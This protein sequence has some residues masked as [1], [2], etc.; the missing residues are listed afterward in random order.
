MLR[1]R[2]AYS[3]IGTTVMAIV[4]SGCTWGGSGNNGASAG[5][6]GGNSGNP[7][8]SNT[9]SASPT[10]T[11]EADPIKRQMQQMSLDDKIGQLVLV[12]L[13]GKAAGKEALEMIA[14]FRV[15]GFILF[16]DNIASAEQTQKL[17]NALKAA[18]AEAKA[19][20]PL[21]LSVDQEGGRVNRL[22]ESFAAFPTNRAIGTIGQPAYAADIGKRLGEAVSAIGFN[23]NYA[24]V[25]D[26]DSNPKNPVIGD[27]SFGPGTDTVSKLGIAEMQGIRSTGVVPVVKHFP[28]HGDTAV[29]SHRALPVV[30]KSLDEL[31]KLELVP[32]QRAIAEK[33]DAVMVAHILLPKLDETYPASLSKAVI[34][35][36]LRG[37]LGFD[38]VV[39]TDDMTMGAVLQNYSI[40]EAAVHAVK[41]GTDI[42]LVAHDYD[43]ETAVL[44]ALKKSVEEGKL[45]MSRINESV[46]RILKLKKAF[47][48][49]DTPVERIDVEGINRNIR[50]T[51]QKHTPKK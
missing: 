51:L 45:S 40:G 42:V 13:E 8:T 49:A 18:N 17:L 12:G 10:A 48:L 7:Q 29:D 25:L 44:G 50:E 34:T 24:P 20:A 30:N 5:P 38:G 4:L 2:M 21:W 22:P 39:I 28:G 26:V 31:K 32:F 14:K 43:K 37:E 9:P 47:K 27:R 6:S 46:Y 36:L 19:A 3:F 11:P 35:D 15:G 16:K 1:G 41:A 33:A 23:M